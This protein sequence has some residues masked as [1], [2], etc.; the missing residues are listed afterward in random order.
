MKRRTFLKTVGTAAGSLA[1]GF[2]P[3]FADPADPTRKLISHPSGLPR[4][5]LGRTGQAISIIGFPGL[6]LSRVTQE[7]ANAA[8]RSAFNQ[9]MNYFDVAP[10]Y[11]KDGRAEITMGPALA[12]LP[13]DQFFL[14]CKTKKRDAA[15][16]MQ[17]LEQSLKRLKTDH[18]ELHQLHVM[19]T[20]ADVKE[21]FGPGG[22]M[23]TLV[24]AQKQGKVRWLGFSAH[25]KEAALECLRHFKFETVMY[26]INF[27]EHYT[28]KFDPEVLTLARQAGTAAIAI[29]AISAGSWKPGEQ[30]TR[31]NYWYKALEDQMEINRATQFTL[32]LDPVVSSIPTSFVDLNERSIIAG[33]AFRPATSADL[34]SMRA[35]AEK[36]SPL[37]P[38]KPLYLGAVGPHT[39]YGS[40]V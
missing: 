4:R 40:H 39:N 18:F 26:P 35:L 13:R 25:T 3:A 31:N 28:H 11:G 37:F 20:A 10:A 1:V 16:A 22:A 21:A 34:E 8:V 32:S 2:N 7:E 5:I 38:R 23:E 19:S 9:G 6:A 27:V 36:Y 24:K 14:S 33:R 30:K 29:K 12:A 17:E 15:G